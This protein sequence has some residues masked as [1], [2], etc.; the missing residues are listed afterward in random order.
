MNDI[1]ATI[2]L[3]NLPHIEGMLEK[4]RANAMFF[5]GHLNN[6]KDI[7]VMKTPDNCRSAYWLYTLRVLNG[8]KGEFMEK[9]K[10]CNIM[11]SQVHNRNDINACVEKYREKLSNLDIMETEL[12]CIPVGWWLT[13]SD[14]E[15]IVDTIKSFI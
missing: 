6:L 10:E 1:N 13:K 15:H 14:L 8:R 11:T 4:N 12:V 5:D 7:K 9:M 3:Y 2:G